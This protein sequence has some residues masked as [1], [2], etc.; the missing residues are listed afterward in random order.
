MIKKIL[1]L[2]SIIFLLQLVDTVEVAA[3]VI[4]AQDPLLTLQEV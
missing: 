4:A 2:R 1:T 3:I